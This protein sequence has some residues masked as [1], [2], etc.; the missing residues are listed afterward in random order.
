MR[1]RLLWLG[2][3]IVAVVL[4]L[5]GWRREPKYEGRPLSAWLLDSSSQ[6]EE[7]RALA[8]EILQHAGPKALPALLRELSW[9]DPWNVKVIEWFARHTHF[10]FNMQQRG[11]RVEAAL[12]AL[13]ALGTNSAPAVP[14]FVRWLGKEPF[15]GAYCLNTVGAALRNHPLAKRAVPI[16][17]LLT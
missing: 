8:R 6:D 3:L 7:T 15:M 12:L 17:D 13:S 14:M 10:R 1:R 2:V 11:Q 5:F 4:V 16:P 9:V